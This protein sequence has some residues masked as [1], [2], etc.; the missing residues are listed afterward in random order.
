MANILITGGTGLIGKALS[1]RLL[2]DGHHVRVLSRTAN[3]NSN[4]PAFFWDV[5]KQQ[6]DI[7]A[8]EGIDH[9]VH[10]AGEAIAD[11]RWSDKRKKEVI[12]SRVKSMELITRAVKKTNIKL[13]SFVGASATGIYGMVTSD[14]IFSETD[15]G[16]NDFLSHT[17]KVWE[18]SYDEIS[19]L[20]DRTTIVRI[21]VVLSKNGG[22]LKRLLPLFK[23]GLGSAVGNGKQYMPWI[24]ID[25]LVSV[26]HHALFNSSFNGVYNAVAPEHINS[27]EFSKALANALHKPFFAPNVPGFVLKIIFGQMANVLLEGSRVSDEKLKSTDFSFKY[28]T[29]KTAFSQIV[30]RK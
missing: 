2:S 11:K 30:T 20:S 17:C 15:Q 4:I 19:K 10:L 1:E 24:H 26:L 6:I 12:D 27:D 8:L 14:K 29:L 22:A 3:A 13:K 25:D 5:E 16:Q 21:S 18:S 23:M 9:I 7:K 28:P